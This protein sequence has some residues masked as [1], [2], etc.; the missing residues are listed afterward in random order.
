MLVCLLLIKL[1]PL[2]GHGT[3]EDREMRLVS[4]ICGF[5]ATAE[6]PP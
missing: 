2:E 3:K 6:M 1:L 5:N 4:L